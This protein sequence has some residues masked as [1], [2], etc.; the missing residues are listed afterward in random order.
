MNAYVLWWHSDGFA[1]KVLLGGPAEEF[2]DDGRVRVGGGYAGVYVKPAFI[3]NRDAGEVL[4]ERA[5]DIRKERDRKIDAARDEAKAE[6][7][8]LIATGEV[9]K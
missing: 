5:E 8:K 3:T 1:G 4:L 7:T 2:R 9:G 6:L